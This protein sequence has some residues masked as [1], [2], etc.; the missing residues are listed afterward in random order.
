VTIDLPG[1]PAAPRSKTYA[2]VGTGTPV[3]RTA[4]HRRHSERRRLAD[5]HDRR[6]RDPPTPLPP[7]TPRPRLRRTSPTRSTPPPRPT[8]FGPPL[9][10]TR[11]RRSGPRKTITFI[12]MGAGAP[13]RPQLLSIRRASAG[14]LQLQPPAAPMAA[15]Y[16]AYPSPGD[17]EA[18]RRVQ[19]PPST[20]WR[21]PTTAG[22]R[23]RRRARW[24]TASSATST[25]A[26]DPD[27]QTGQPLN[28][29]VHASTHRQRCD[30]RRDNGPVRPVDAELQTRLKPPPH[31]QPAPGCFPQEGGRHRVGQHPAWGDPD[32]PRST[33]SPWCIKSRTAS[34]PPAA[35]RAN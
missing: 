8:R 28:L 16:T 21:S 1:S 2:L 20:A 32:P 5:H 33:A 23:G 10:P 6:H 11:L 26:P 14:R 13:F 34:S 12:V 31:L 24:P 15:H 27:P 19:T 30:R 9:N 25:G 22:R 17:G 18:G 3:S 29:E 7:T 4:S 35:H